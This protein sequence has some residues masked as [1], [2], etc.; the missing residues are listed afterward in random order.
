MFA[1]IMD[2]IYEPHNPNSFSYCFRQNTIDYNL[3][4]A[5]RI[6]PVQTH[7]EQPFKKMKYGSMYFYFKIT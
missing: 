6:W 2:T 4:S 3:I 1:M 7:L 5:D